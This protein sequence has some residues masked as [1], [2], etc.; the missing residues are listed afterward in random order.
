[1]FF[2]KKGNRELWQLMG[3]A[4]IMGLHMVSGILVGLVIGLLLDRWLGTKPLFFFIF[5]IVGI[6]AGF[7]NVYEEARKFIEPKS[8]DKQDNE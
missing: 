8:N 4:S 5:L 6:I 1:M 3:S 2:K 7:K